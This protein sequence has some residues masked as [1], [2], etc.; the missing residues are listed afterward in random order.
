VPFQ[1]LSVPFTKPADATSEKERERERE[2]GRQG[3]REC[4]RARAA[5]GAL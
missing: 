3:Q 4:V 1:V 5:F 2:T